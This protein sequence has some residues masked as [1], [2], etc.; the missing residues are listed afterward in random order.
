MAQ[1]TTGM[2]RQAQGQLKGQ[3]VAVGRGTEHL[4]LH[5]RPHGNK[6]WS[7]LSK[8]LLTIGRGGHQGT[9]LLGARTHTHVSPWPM[10]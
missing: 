9:D 7:S 5:W 1:H 4:A 3:E 8:L 6:S 2:A 10:A